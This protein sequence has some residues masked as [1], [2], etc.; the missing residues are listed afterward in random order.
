MATS[1]ARIA[2]RYGGASVTLVGLVGILISIAAIQ[3]NFRNMNIGRLVLLLLLLATHVSC[4]VYYYR[5][6]LLVPADAYAYYFDPANFG[7]Q[8]WGLSTTLVTQLCYILKTRFGGTYLDCFL[9]FQAFGFGGIMLLVRTFDEI[10]ANV[11]VPESRASWLL[12]FLP[13]ANF[14]TSGIG[15]DAPL[16]FAISL[17][18]WSAMR[19]RSR[20]PYLCIA[21]CVMALFRAHVA[22]MAAMALAGTAFF[23]SS[24][25]LG[26]KLGFLVL[27]LAGIWV[28]TGAVESTFGLNAT[29]IASVFD[30]LDE[31][32]NSFVTIAGATSVGDAPYPVRVL[33]LLFR[34]FFVD[35]Q[36]AMGFIASLENVGVAFLVLYFLVRAREV[37]YLSRRVPFVRFVLLFAFILLF[38]L[39]LIYYN[40]GMGL[41]ERVMSYPMIFSALVAI[42]SY[43]R[44]RGADATPPPHALMAEATGNRPVPGL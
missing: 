10:A 39:S 20:L 29:S 3:I 1:R 44:K 13:S 24:A 30:F 28:A 40:V 14:W 21:L 15:K 5:W 27:G 38:L 6:S 41:R 22:L 11:V 4:S 19:M 17:C 33:S 23:G 2:Y 8:R 32:Y 42:W 25:T 35:A 9:V 37:V 34:P 7:L 43:R 31:K 12:L 26:R 36:G 16:F 18:V